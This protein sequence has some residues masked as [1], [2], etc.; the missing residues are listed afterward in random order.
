MQFAFEQMLQPWQ[1]GY[2]SETLDII[3]KMLVSEQFDRIMQLEDIGLTASEEC[4]LAE[5]IA[6]LKAQ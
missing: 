4:R 2:A 1:Q 3:K 5:V 6:D